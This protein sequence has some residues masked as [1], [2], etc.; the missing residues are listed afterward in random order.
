M[1]RHGAPQIRCGNQRAAMFPIPA[2]SYRRR[3]VGKKDTVLPER[4]RHR[5][6]LS[7][8]ILLCLSRVKKFDPYGSGIPNN[9]NEKECNAMITE[10]N[11]KKFYIIFAQFQAAAEGNDRN[12]VETII[13]RQTSQSR[14][15][16]TQCF[17]VACEKKNKTRWQRWVTPLD[18]S[19]RV[20]ICTSRPWNS[21]G[22]F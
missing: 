21:C 11:N 7:V 16:G 6:Q 20:C 10:T 9:F 18:C 2:T 13:V 4:G 19:C 15:R 1:Q 3:N 17:D 12:T 22:S 8:Y 5:S 14:H